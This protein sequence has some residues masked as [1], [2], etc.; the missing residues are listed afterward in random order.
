MV[1]NGGLRILRMLCFPPEV[2]FEGQVGK[3]GF[4]AKIR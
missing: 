3:K 4:C 2:M 1:L